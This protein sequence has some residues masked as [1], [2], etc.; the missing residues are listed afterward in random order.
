ME[1]LRPHLLQAYRI[2]QA[3]EQIHERER[4]ERE[5]VAAAVD[6][7]LCQIDAAG[8]IEWMT[9]K[10][11]P[12]LARYFPAPHPRPDRLPSELR[13]LLHTALGAGA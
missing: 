12:L 10:V 2:A 6:G 13:A 8:K 5:D 11:E 7:G 3:T 4:A 1:M 9:A